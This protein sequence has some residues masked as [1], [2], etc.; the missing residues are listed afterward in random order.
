VHTKLVSAAQMMADFLESMHT[1]TSASCISE[2][3]V[4]KLTSRETFLLF[5]KLFLLF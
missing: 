5:C 4:W 3:L 1:D 2:P